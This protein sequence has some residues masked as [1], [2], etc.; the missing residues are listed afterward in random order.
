MLPMTFYTYKQSPSG[1]LECHLSLGWNV[2][3]LALGHVH[4]FPLN[5]RE[6][7]AGCTPQRAAIKPTRY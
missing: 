4:A 3:S 6:I 1:V 2:V 7:S 5:N